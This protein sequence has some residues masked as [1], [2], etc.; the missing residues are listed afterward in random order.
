MLVANAPLVVAALVAAMEAL[1]LPLSTALEMA[2][3]TLLRTLEARSMTELTS[4]C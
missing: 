1:S 3:L 4:L 2:P